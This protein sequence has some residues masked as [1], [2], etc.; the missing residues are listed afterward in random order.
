MRSRKDEFHES[1]K[2]PG[3]RDS[4]DSWNSSFLFIGE[5]R[6]MRGIGATRER[7]RNKMRRCQDKPSEG[8]SSPKRAKGGSSIPLQWKKGEG[9]GSVRLNNGVEPGFE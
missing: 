9:E 2:M 1:L 4:R 8:R 3:P 6:G 5:K 7:T